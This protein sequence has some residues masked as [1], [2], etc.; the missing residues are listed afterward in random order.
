VKVRLQ[1]QP[2]DNRLYTGGFDCLMKLLKN[3][4]ILALYK[5]SFNELSLENPYIR[6]FGSF[7]W[8]WPL[9]FNSIWDGWNHE[10]SL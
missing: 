2:Y 3:E 6:Y 7:A 4:G 8:L 10:E 9:S 1:T 5:G